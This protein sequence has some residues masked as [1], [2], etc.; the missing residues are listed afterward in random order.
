M[1]ELRPQP[2]P[3]EADTAQLEEETGAHTQSARRG[4]AAPE[5]AQAG[6]AAHATQ[7]GASEPVQHAEFAV[8][9]G[10][11]PPAWQPTAADVSP[12]RGAQAGA[13]MDEPEIEL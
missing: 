9:A 11:E 12:E 10:V 7:A 2:E 4:A 1:P 8:R 6:R 13:E 3:A 5:L